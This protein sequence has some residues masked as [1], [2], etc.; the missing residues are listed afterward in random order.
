MC[1]EEDRQSKILGRIDELIFLSS[2][3]I[4][5]RTLEY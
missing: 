4:S 3:S 2:P 1:D 5:L